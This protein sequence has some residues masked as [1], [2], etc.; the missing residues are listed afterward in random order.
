[1][2][3]CK[4]PF[5]NKVIKIYSIGHSSVIDY[6]LNGS[7][8]YL[9]VNIISTNTLSGIIRKNSVSGSSSGSQERTGK[10]VSFASDYTRIVSDTFDL[11]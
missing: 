6:C 9:S 2:L 7:N 4:V 10:G 3:L 5:Y 1:M 8:S 11:L